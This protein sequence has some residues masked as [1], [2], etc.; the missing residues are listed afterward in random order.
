MILNIID[1]EFSVC[2]V[3]QSSKIGIKKR[4]DRFL[5]PVLASHGRSPWLSLASALTRGLQIIR[6]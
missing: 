3:A 4:K 5:I 1:E 6:L 2:K